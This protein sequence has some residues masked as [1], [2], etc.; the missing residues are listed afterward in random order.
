MKTPLVLTSVDRA[1]LQVR[2]VDPDHD[3]AEAIVLVG[4]LQRLSNRVHMLERRVYGLARHRP[5]AVDGLSG[6]NTDASSR[7][8]LEE[9]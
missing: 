2:G 5:I 9:T 8:A 6:P 4:R 1:L 7:L 3:Q